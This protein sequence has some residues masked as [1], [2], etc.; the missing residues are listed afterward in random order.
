MKEG[1]LFL[2]VPYNILN[3]CGQ[4]RVKSEIA[5]K[6]NVTYSHAT[7]VF[8]KCE[9]LGL[10]S[11]SSRDHRSQAVSVT[12][13]GRQVLNHINNIRCWMAYNE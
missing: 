4:G 5:R 8:K 1:I 11:F 13:K 10:V 7:R 2:K 3:A 12:P 9:D 6:C